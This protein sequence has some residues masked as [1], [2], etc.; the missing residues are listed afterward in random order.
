MVLSKGKDLL[1]IVQGLTFLSGTVHH[2]K[3]TLLWGK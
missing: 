3:A 1:L 2:Q